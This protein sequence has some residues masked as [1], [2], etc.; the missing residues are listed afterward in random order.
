MKARLLISGL[1]IAML[2]LTQACT[3]S[4]D[5]EEPCNFVQSSQLQRVSWKQ[6]LPVKLMVHASVPQ[7][8]WPFIENAVKHWNSEL[9]KQGLKGP[10]L[11]IDLWGVGG[12]IAQEQDFNNIIYW[13]P[14]WDMQKQEQQALTTIYWTGSRIYEAD[15]RVNAQNFQFIFENDLTTEQVAEYKELGVENETSF[16]HFES[17]MIHEFG[18]V[19]GLAHNSHE[20][21]VMQ[22][23]LASGVERRVLGEVDSKSVSCE[24]R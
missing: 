7:E 2:L 14:T 21:S 12:P 1:T 3:R 23:A 22:T 17:L 4:L 5:P 9:S 10:A 11:I 15:I 20:S 6:D 18:H 8:A 16:V 13:M 19:L 24:Y